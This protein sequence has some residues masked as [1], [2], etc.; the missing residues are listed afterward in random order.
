MP[1]VISRSIVCSDS[2][3]QEEY[4]DSKQA[5][6]IYYCLCGSLSLIIDCELE[7]LP[8]RKTDGARVIDGSQHANKLSME[9]DETV[10]IRRDKGVEKQFRFKVSR[11]LHCPF[12]TPSNHLHPAPFQCK[13][14]SLPVYY[15]HD[16]GSNVTFILK[17]ALVKS[18]QERPDLFAKPAAVAGG[19]AAAAA[20]AAKKVMI[21]KQT[22]NMGKFS[23][24]TVSTMDEE[25]DEIESQ[26]V[27]TS[28][29][30]NAKIIET[31]LQR[32]G[33]PPSK[34]DAVEPPVVPA[35][36]ARG[37]LLDM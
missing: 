22:K 13:K 4:S 19:E 30:K 12:R 23:S 8:L 29:A 9:P 3:D 33:G 24:V 5:L 10:Y 1:K 31:K 36:K 34:T 17:L 14:C 6:H 2:K 32:K 27:A 11:T 16:P 25:E 7:L 18:K 35:K 26:E 28:Y 37:T 21:T 20:G 15:K